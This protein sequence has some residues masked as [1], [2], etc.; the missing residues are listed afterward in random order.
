MNVTPT[1]QVLFSVESHFLVQVARS[2]HVGIA[3]GEPQN[4]SRIH[5][6]VKHPPK[7]MF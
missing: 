7:K 5:Q 3:E 2:Q 1:K 4:E 6:V